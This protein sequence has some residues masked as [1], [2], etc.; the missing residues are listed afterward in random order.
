MCILLNCVYLP[1]VC[2]LMHCVARVTI[3]IIMDSALDDVY[4]RE[5][6]IFNKTCLTI[7][8]SLYDGH[9]HF[10]AGP[11]ERDA[12]PRHSSEDVESVVVRQ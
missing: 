3:I 1:D 4:L 9:F 8:L 2:N 11:T 7:Y 6:I 12:S 10:P 5:S